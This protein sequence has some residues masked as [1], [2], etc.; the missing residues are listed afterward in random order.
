MDLHFDVANEQRESFS[1]RN[2]TN[3]SSINLMFWLIANSDD[4]IFMAFFEVE[5][6]KA[7]HCWSFTTAQIANFDGIFLQ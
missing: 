1:E 7:S 4:R 5:H 3:Y 6:T 2:S